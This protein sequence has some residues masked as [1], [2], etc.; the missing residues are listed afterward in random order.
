MAVLN[1]HTGMVTKVAFSPDGKR[2]LTG[3]VDKT[4]LVWDATMGP[5]A[6]P[7]GR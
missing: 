2:V 5:G 4:A 7:P 1:G 6:L 3:S